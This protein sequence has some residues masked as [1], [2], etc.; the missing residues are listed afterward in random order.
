MLPIPDQFVS[1]KRRSPQGIINV[2]KVRT[3]KKKCTSKLPSSARPFLSGSR[4]RACS[5]GLHRRNQT[6]FHRHKLEIAG[7]I[8]AVTELVE[9]RNITTTEVRDK[10]ELHIQRKALK[11]Y[12]VVGSCMGKLDAV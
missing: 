7:K 10:L 1:H 11:G 12:E 6:V 5:Q 9:A 2:P 4:R 3:Y 8:L